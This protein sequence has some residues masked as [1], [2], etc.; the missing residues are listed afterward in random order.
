MDG[1]F[2]AYLAMILGYSLS[3][4]SSILGIMILGASSPTPARRRKGLNYMLAGFV[5]RII[6]L[7][8]AYKSDIPFWIV[9]IGF[10]LPISLLV[11]FS[12]SF[13]M[14]ERLKKRKEKTRK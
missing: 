10:L 2:L 8:V 4:F 7:I 6:V 11:L 1:I 3:L 14:S 12:I 13:E 9:L 5:V